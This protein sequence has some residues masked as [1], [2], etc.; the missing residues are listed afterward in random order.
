[1]P[2]RTGISRRRRT[3]SVTEPS[4]DSP[5]PVTEPSYDSPSPVTE[6]SYDY[7]PDPDPSYDYSPDPQAP[8]RME[9]F[10]ERA[11]ERIQVRYHQR[12]QQ[13]QKQLEQQQQKQQ[14]QQEQQQQL[15]RRRRQDAGRFEAEQRMAGQRR[16]EL[17][18]ALEQQATLFD[19]L[20][21]SQQERRRTL[22]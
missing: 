7:S 15:R 13:R 21:L 10:E 14:K 5:S 1:M 20:G 2:R 16:S 4:Y 17:R 9:D 19:I 12:A 11:Q 6:P 8:E 18:S 22:G 3:G